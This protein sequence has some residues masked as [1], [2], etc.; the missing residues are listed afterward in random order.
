MIN[1]FLNLKLFTPFLFEI[2]VSI[3][4]KIREKTLEYLITF[5]GVFENYEVYFFFNIC[6]SD[7]NN[8]YSKFEIFTKLNEP[9]FF[10]IWQTWR[11]F[12][13]TNFCSYYNIPSALLEIRNISSNLRCNSRSTFYSLFNFSENTAYLE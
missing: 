2:N 12:Y 4:W 9:S 8:S 1:T 7:C 5:S 11:L 10:E 6:L 3:L 13:K